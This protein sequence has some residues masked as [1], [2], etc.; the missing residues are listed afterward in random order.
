MFHRL[1]SLQS[2]FLTFTRLVAVQNPDLENNISLVNHICETNITSLGQH[3]SLESAKMATVP[4]TSSVP[5]IYTLVLTTIEPIF[6][7]LGAAMA[8]TDP[9]SYL[10]AMSRDSVA[11]SGPTTFLYTELAGAWLYFAFVEAVV[12]RLYDDLRLWRLLCAGMLLSDAAYAHSAAQAVGGWRAWA[13]VGEWSTMDWWVLATTA[14]MLAV[15]VLLVLG[16]GV[17]KGN[18]K[19]KAE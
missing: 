13:A 14:P 10:S 7:S 16:V 6:A 4:A 2:S 17:K 3:S 19:G 12:L 8:L 1:A 15:R 11:F 18:G 9:A 5:F